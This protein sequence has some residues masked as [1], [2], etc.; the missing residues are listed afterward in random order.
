MNC[1]TARASILEADPAELGSESES[2]LGEHLRGCP[3]CR[4]AASSVLG[5]MTLLD[6][7]L[8][9]MPRRPVDAILDTLPGRRDGRVASWVPWGI[10]AAIVAGLLLARPW[11]PETPP[12]HAPVALAAES[13]PPVVEDADG[14]PV[15]VFATRDP[16]ITVVWIYEEERP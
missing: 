11:S 3:S 8:A 14:G 9:V 7:G 10:V 16:S 15:A 12:M 6:E 4:A 1:E 2:P 13:S 5:G